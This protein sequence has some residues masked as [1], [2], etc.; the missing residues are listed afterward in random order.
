MVGRRRGTGPWYGDER[1]RSLFEWDA[2]KIYPSLR[3]RRSSEGIEYTTTVPVTGYQDRGVRVVFPA[4]SSPESVR[5]YAD[6][7]E[8]SPHRYPDSGTLCIWYPSDP[9][10]RRWMQQDGLV[11][12]LDLIAVH[13]FMEA[14]WR[15]TDDWLGDEA[16]H[17][18]PE[19]LQ[20]GS[21]AGSGH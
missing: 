17:G 16:P 21:S 4:G 11:E 12:L 13:L 14:F 7:P 6:G 9:K 3:S 5:I 1:V 18:W 19:K 15:D 10:H 8:S 20:V 2:K